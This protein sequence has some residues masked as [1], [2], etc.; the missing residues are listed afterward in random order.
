MVHPPPPPWARRQSPSPT[1]PLQEAL[2]LGPGAPPQ[3]HWRRSAIPPSSQFSKAARPL[4]PAFSEA[5][6][7]L[8][9]AFS[10]A[11]G[12][13]WKANPGTGTTTLPPLPPPLYP[14]PPKPFRSAW[15]EPPIYTRR[16]DHFPSSLCARYGR[17]CLRRGATY[18]C[19]HRDER[20]ALD[21]VTAKE[22]VPTDDEQEFSIPPSLIATPPS[23]PCE[24]YGTEMPTDDEQEFSI[25][26]TLAPPSPLSS[27]PRPKAIL[28]RPLPRAETPSAIVASLVAVCPES[29]FGPFI[30]HAERGDLRLPRQR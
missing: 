20:T 10:K 25:P 7:A 24:A 8:S 11:A 16:R 28:P 26:S 6:G 12:L 22:E 15:P 5:A 4:A 1:I 18:R 19:N 13:A 30:F 3:T 9:P 21:Y 17:A 2:P 29:Q 27:S 14:S 23:S